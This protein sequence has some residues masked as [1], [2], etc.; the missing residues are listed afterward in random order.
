MFFNSIPSGLKTE[1]E[2]SLDKVPQNPYI[3]GKHGGEG[4]SNSWCVNSLIKNAEI[5][6]H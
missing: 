2:L 1:V 4:T 5:F 3:T 6:N